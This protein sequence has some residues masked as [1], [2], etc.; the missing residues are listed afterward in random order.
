MWLP[1]GVP[2]GDHFRHK[3]A[4]VRSI[5]TLL[6]PHS[7][8]IPL[9]KPI[10]EHRTEDR[11]TDDSQPGI[12]P[13]VGKK[14]TSSNRLN[15][16]RGYASCREVRYI[17]R[18]EAGSGRM[19]DSG[20][21]LDLFHGKCSLVPFRADKTDRWLTIIGQSIMGAGQPNVC[22]VHDIA[23]PPNCRITQ[24]PGGAYCFCSVRSL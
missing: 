3:D 23:Y 4:E 18:P 2:R 13:R 5:I 1:S 11:K 10:P 14:I 7:C 24:Q 20:N 17:R 16:V 12:S 15:W 21:R 8:G 6:L 9:T 22:P 19:L